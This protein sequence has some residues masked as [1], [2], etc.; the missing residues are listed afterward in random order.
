M[1]AETYSAETYSAETYSAETYSFPVVILGG[2]FAGAYCAR[3]LS[4]GLRQAAA[5]AVALVADQNVMLFHPM[6][7]EVSGSSHLAA[8]RRQYP[9]PI[10]PGRRRG[11]RPGGSDRALLARGSIPRSFVW[12]WCTVASTSYRRSVRSWAL[13]RGAPPKT[14]D[15]GASQRAPRRLHRRTRHSGHC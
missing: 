14:G 12:S 1:S 8:P 11:R 3:A 2:G 15:R 10:L 7:A 5:D 9:A 6:L 13:L 4:A